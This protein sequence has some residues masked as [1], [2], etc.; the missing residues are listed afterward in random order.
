MGGKR[1]KQIELG[2][3]VIESIRDF[4]VWC[5]KDPVLSNE[6]RLQAE[7]IVGMTTLLFCEGRFDRLYSEKTGLARKNIHVDNVRDRQ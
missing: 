5:S 7:T 6:C 1:A 4:H 2:D 3:A